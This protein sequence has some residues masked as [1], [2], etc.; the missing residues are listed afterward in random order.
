M[1]CSCCDF[2][3]LLQLLNY[4]H[5]YPTTQNP[6]ISLRSNRANLGPRLA[7]PA[8]PGTSS[9]PSSSSNPNP[10]PT[11]NPKGKGKGKN[12]G[13]NKATTDGIPPGSSKGKAKGKNKGKDEATETIHNED[14]QP[15]VKTAVQE[16]KKVFQPVIYLYMLCTR[17]MKHKVI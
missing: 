2:A 10:T 11:P 15:K 9:E 3:N 8:L 4:I 1:L 14:P 6:K 16:A 12:K 13:K 17:N 7:S 5:I